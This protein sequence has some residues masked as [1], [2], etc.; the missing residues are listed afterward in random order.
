MLRYILMLMSL[1]LMFS[2]LLA[3]PMSP[4]HGATAPP[5]TMIISR[6]SLFLT[7]LQGKDRL[8]VVDLSQKKAIVI[9]LPPVRKESGTMAISTAGDRLYIVGQSGTI[10]IID[11]RQQKVINTLDILDMFE[12]SGKDLDIAGYLRKSGLKWKIFLI[13][14]IFNFTYKPQARIHSLTLGPEGK[15]LYIALGIRA[16]AP[17]LYFEDIPLLLVLDLPSLA[18]Q[19][20]FLWGEAATSVKK[21][22]GKEHIYFDKKADRILLYSKGTKAYIFDRAKGNFEIISLDKKAR[23]QT[24]NVSKSPM[25]EVGEWSDWADPVVHGRNIYLPIQKQ[26]KDGEAGIAVIDM[27]DD[28]IDRFYLGATS[29]GSHGAI[30]PDG[31]R[32]YLVFENLW[33]VDLQ[34]RALLHHQTLGGIYAASAAMSLDGGELYL[35][36]PLG[37]L[38]T[39]DA[40]TY[41]VLWE[42]D[43]S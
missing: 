32:L 1:P 26:G 36:S 39:R 12:K 10:L 15:T 33:V 16:E 14:Q 18:V 20:A 3:V 40:S 35:L 27:V 34:K 2:L 11:P 9:P 30:S 19:C 17:S 6:G 41:N 42:M 29:I 28:K 8:V 7:P 13:S 4:A 25:L 21:F 24:L 22:P 23:I 31:K 43:L 37:T 5:L 38:Q